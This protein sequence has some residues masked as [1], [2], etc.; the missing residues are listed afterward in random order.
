MSRT[1]QA[2]GNLRIKAAAVIQPA[3]P[4]PTMTILCLRVP[5]SLIPSPS[6]ER[7]P[8]AI[9]RLPCSLARAQKRKRAP[10]DI[11]VSSKRTKR[12]KVA[13]KPVGAPFGLTTSVRVRLD[14]NGSP[15]MF[16]QSPKIV[17]F[18]RML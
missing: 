10:I 8:E 4:P 6:K 13:S 12:G 15:R 11:V 7:E 18:S 3:V 17:R 14:V 9:P 5:L 16:V 2:C 1:E